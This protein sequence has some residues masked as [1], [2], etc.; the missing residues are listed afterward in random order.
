MSVN[1]DW[2]RFKWRGRTKLGM[3][4]AATGRE[5]VRGSCARTSCIASCVRRHTN[6]RGCSTPRSSSGRWGDG[7]VPTNLLDMLFSRKK[8]KESGEIGENLLMCTR[9]MK[10]MVCN[11]FSGHGKRLSSFQD[12]ALKF[13]E[14]HVLMSAGSFWESRELS[15]MQNVFSSR[16]APTRN[17]GPFLS[18]TPL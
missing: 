17:S 6:S 5:N 2:S 13:L 12:F 10:A 9:S 3:G 18:D 14:M 4:M 11:I 1:C 16:A 15:D 8:L 7:P